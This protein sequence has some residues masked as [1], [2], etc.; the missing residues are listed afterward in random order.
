MEGGRPGTGVIQTEELHR[1]EHEALLAWTADV[2]GWRQ[3]GTHQREIYPVLLRVR[4]FRHSGIIERCSKVDPTFNADST[5]G[6]NP[7]YELPISSGDFT[8][9]ANS[10]IYDTSEL[11]GAHSAAR[12]SRPKHGA[13]QRLRRW[14]RSSE[15]AAASWMLDDGVAKAPVTRRYSTSCRFRGWESAT[16][17]W[18]LDVGVVAAWSAVDAAIKRRVAGLRSPGQELSFT[19]IR[20]LRMDAAPP[21]LVLMFTEFGTEY[22]ST[23]QCPTFRGRMGAHNACPSIVICLQAMPAGSPLNSGWGHEPV[24]GFFLS[25]PVVDSSS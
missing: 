1:I 17:P 18:S 13:E 4:I 19:R 24:S 16:A 21:V 11:V 3:E 6:A 5:G 14:D 9:A 7:S 2:E 15:S 20:M 25:V 10:R 12:I 23:P 22:G 8:R